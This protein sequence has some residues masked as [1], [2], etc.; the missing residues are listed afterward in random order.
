MEHTF[1]IPLWTSIPFALMLLS[2]AIIPL[3]AEKWWEKN[4]NKLLISGLLSIPV[5]IYLISEGLSI[6]LADTVLYDY[7]PFIVLL[8]TLFV[9]TGGIHI[10]GDIVASPKNNT[11][12]LGIGY[13]LAS[14]MGTTGAAMLLIRP[15]LSTNNERKFKVHTILFFIATVANCGGLLTPL[16]DPLGLGVGLGLA[17]LQQGE[18]GG[19][20]GHGYI[21]ISSCR[22]R[23]S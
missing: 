7:I 11:I 4:K 21:S 17:A 22:A 14:L 16:G 23:A 10:S 9:V 18:Q 5:V 20:V 19:F 2:I 12:F 1:N 3:V 13:V 6:K 15:V 8:G